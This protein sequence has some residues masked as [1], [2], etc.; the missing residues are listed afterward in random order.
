MHP[1]SV[2]HHPTE[3][4]VRH[5]SVSIPTTVIRPTGRWGQLDAIQLW[6]YRELVYFMVWRDLKARYKQAV[7]GVGWVVLQPLFTM[8]I[9]TFIFSYLARVPS[10]GSP[11]PVFAFAALVPWTYFAQ[12]VS[13]S[14]MGLVNSAGLISKVYF[15]RLIIPL[16]SVTTP[17]A[18][19]LLALAV[20]FGLLAWYQIMPSAAVLLLPA[21]IFMAFLAAFS[22]GLWLSALNV[23][24][25]DVV[26][27]IPFIVQV[28]ML[29]SPVAYPVSLVPPQWQGLYAL[30]PMVAVI[31]GFRWCLLSA[32][33]PTLEMVA[34]GS[35]TIVV[36][37]ASGLMYF[38]ATARTFADII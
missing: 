23:R 6:E 36:L 14:G 30:N 15:P 21:F 20:L 22:L 29:A 1:V 5:A 26:H 17:F 11:Y 10:D 33:G 32:P 27:V 12:A 4:T 28:G 35:L 16:A 38:I 37:L 18:D 7:L 31:E 8:F 24:Y 19:F 9:F 3:Q 13:R 34:L 2:T 25:R